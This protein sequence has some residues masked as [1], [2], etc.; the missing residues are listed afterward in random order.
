[1]AILPAF[2]GTSLQTAWNIVRSGF[3]TLSLLD[4]GWYGAGIYFV[5][6][7]FFREAFTILGFFFRPIYFEGFFSPGGVLN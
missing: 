4:S 7:F 2:H 5:C 6:V 1:V 3:A